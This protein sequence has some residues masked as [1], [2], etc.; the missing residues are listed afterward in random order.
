ML[1]LDAFKS[2]SPS[3]HLRPLCVSMSTSAFPGHRSRSGQRQ[4]GARQHGRQAVHAEASTCVCR[5][6]ALAHTHDPEVRMGWRS[7]TDAGAAPA[8][9]PRGQGV[10]T[11]GD[12]AHTGPH[13]WSGHL[14]TVHARARRTAHS[15]R[16]HTRQTAR[17]PMPTPLRTWEPVH[18]ARARVRSTC[19]HLAVHCPPCACLSAMCVHARRPGCA[20]AVRHTCLCAVRRARARPGHAVPLSSVRRAPSVATRASPDN[21]QVDAL[22]G[23]P[24]VGGGV[25]I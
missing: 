5:S 20:R 4:H 19:A 12:R 18:H 8:C 1:P 24:L 17:P 6:S 9:A 7:C 3:P 14:Q 25:G 13:A 23:V 16:M 22:L 15:A 2:S 10:H 11:H 21:A